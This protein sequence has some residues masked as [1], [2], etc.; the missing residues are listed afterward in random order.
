MAEVDSLEI[1]IQSDAT[2]ASQSIDTLVEKLK[3]VSAA[4]GGINT[5]ALS[6][7]AKEL[8]G[9]LSA[10]NGKGFENLNKSAKEAT[11]SVAKISQTASEVAKG[12]HNKFKDISVE[13]D[14]S[15]PEKELQ[16]F[17]KQAQTA[18]NALSRIMMSSSVDKQITAQHISC[19]GK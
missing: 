14:F 2:K 10:I 5:N 4:L 11:G 3:D 13:V 9:K 12:L 17:Q 19:T 16:K 15:N 8:T 7:S 18:Q 1:K 6:A